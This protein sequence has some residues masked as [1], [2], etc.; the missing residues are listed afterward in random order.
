MEEVEEEEEHLVPGA[1]P[2]VA[3][4]HHGE[5]LGAYQQPGGRHHLHGGGHAG[6]VEPEAVAGEEGEEDGLVYG[7]LL[8][9]HVLQHGG[10]AGQVPRLAVQAHLGEG[11]VRV[12]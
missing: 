3:G 1:G 2:A 12:G 8:L 4:R 5:G 7:H 6:V 11:E 10:G 9:L